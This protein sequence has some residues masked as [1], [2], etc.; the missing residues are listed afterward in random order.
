[1]T[2]QSMY[3]SGNF[4]SFL[5]HRRNVHFPA[6]G[7]LNIGTGI[8]PSSFISKSRLLH[9]PGRSNL[10][11]MLSF[12]FPG[13]FNTVFVRLSKKFFSICM[14]SRLCRRRWFS[15]YGN[16]QKILFFTQLRV[17]PYPDI[18]SDGLSC[19]F[20]PHSTYFDKPFILFILSR[21]ISSQVN[22]SGGRSKTVFP[23]LNAWVF[24]PVRM[25]CI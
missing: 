22:H 10:L 16:S 7:S 2:F 20:P 11:L 25:I 3:P 13:A 6:F 8:V 24:F 15:Q 12:V 14:K 17:T 19:P 5:N 18:V 21:N 1:M 9:S 23:R 4:I